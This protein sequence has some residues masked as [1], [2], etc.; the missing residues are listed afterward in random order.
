VSACP[1]CG[2]VT[3]DPAHVETGFCYVRCAACDLVRMDPLPGPQ[4]QAE[5]HQ[6]YLPEKSPDER[7]FDLKNREVWTRA[8]RVL[9]RRI[10]RGRVLDI[11]CG[12]GAFLSLM[13]AAG[14]E[15]AGLEVCDAGLARAEARG[16]EVVRSSVEDAPFDDGSF[17]AVTA[18]YVLEHVPQPMEFLA[19]CRRLLKPGGLLYLRVPDT[20]PLKDRLARFGI[21]NRLYDAPFHVLDF[22]P[23]AL[24][25]ALER[26]SFSEIEIRV[27]GFSIPVSGRDRIVGV[28]TAVLG[29]VIDLATRGRVLLRGVSKSAVARKGS[30]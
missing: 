10:G 9:L 3:H 27:G 24:R 6:H 1:V 7:T 16:I 15:T 29:D 25:S 18:F 30:A 8:R 17:D 13:A 12:H 5:R 19:A 20:T 22:S 28:P 14:W 23:L 11:G 26:A 4:E 21:E 2:S